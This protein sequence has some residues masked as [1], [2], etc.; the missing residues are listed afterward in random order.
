VDFVV[1]GGEVITGLEQGVT[2][3]QVGEKRKIKIPAA[4]GYGKRATGKIPA[5]STLLFD[6]TLTSVGDAA[7]DGDDEDEASG[8]ADDDGGDEYA[9]GE[10]DE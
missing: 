4:L 6:V 5:N 2:G 9:G 3:M 1:G 10:D 7:P 8:G